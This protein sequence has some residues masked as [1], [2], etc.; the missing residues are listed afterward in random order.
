MLVLL[1]EPKVVHLNRQNPRNQGGQ[2]DKVAKESSGHGWRN[3]EPRAGSILPLSQL[4]AKSLKKFVNKINNSVIQGV[5]QV[6]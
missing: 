2:G 1:R 5:L 6:H 4:I 3:R